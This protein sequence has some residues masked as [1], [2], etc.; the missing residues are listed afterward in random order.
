MQSNQTEEKKPKI[1]PKVLLFLPFALLLIIVTILIINFNSNRKTISLLED[2]SSTRLTVGEVKPKVQKDKNRINILV[3]GIGGDNHDG[4]MLTDTI[5]FTSIDTVNNKAATLNIP[6]DLFVDLGNNYGYTKIN[7]ANA[8]GEQEKAGSGMELLTTKVEEILNQ[9][10]K[11]YLRIDFNGFEKIIDELGGITVNVEKSFTDNQYPTEDFGYKVVSFSAGTQ[12]MSG[13]TALEYARSRHGNNGEGSDFARSKRQ[14]QILTAVK[15][16]VFSSDGIY[17]PTKLFSLIGEFKK[18]ISTNIGYKDLY[19]LYKLA[20][21]IDKNNIINKNLSE[22]NGYVYTA[23]T[24]DGASIVKP[25][26]NNFT[27]IQDLAKNMFDETYDPIQEHSKSLP[28]IVILN[29]TNIP[30]LAAKITEQIKNLQ[31][32]SIYYV[33]NYNIGTINKSMIYDTSEKSSIE[34]LNLLNK[35]L[36]MNTLSRRTNIFNSYNTIELQTE[37][38]LQELDNFK[39]LYSEADIVLLIGADEASLA[40]NK[41]SM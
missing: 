26:G 16:K 13:Y 35:T 7:A 20:T 10:I 24:L 9:D 28:K 19:T 33:G 32:F 11:Y 31:E 37:D 2:E 1:N 23:M 34:K 14:Q 27:I 36:E 8:F 3:A 6:R 21:N 4:G 38:K 18:N 40:E 39:N 30:G 5:L 17:N 25:V 41:I 15:D 22:S 12:Y 29:G